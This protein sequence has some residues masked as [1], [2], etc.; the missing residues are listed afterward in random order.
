[1]RL[2]RNL[3]HGLNQLQIAGKEKKK[4]TIGVN[5]YLIKDTREIVTFREWYQM[6]SPSYIATG[7]LEGCQK[8]KER[9]EIGK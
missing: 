1:M 8:N 9:L 3:S 5:Y 7:T 2:I 6:G 4:N